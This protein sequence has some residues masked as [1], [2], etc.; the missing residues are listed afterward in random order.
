MRLSN[1]MLTVPSIPLRALCHALRLTAF[2]L[3]QQESGTKKWRPS[4]R[5]RALLET[6]TIGIALVCVSK[7]RDQGKKEEVPIQLVFTEKQK[8]GT[9]N[10]HNSHS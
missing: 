7:V 9:S 3:R 8:K 4:V 5:T 1:I 2:G 10:D 6:G